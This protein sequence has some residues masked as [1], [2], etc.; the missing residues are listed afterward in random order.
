MFLKIRKSL[1]RCQRVQWDQ[2]INIL[3]NVIIIIFLF[4]NIREPLSVFICQH[5]ECYIN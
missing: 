3:L 5:I 1:K 2:N 4:L